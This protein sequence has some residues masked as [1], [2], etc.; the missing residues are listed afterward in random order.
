MKMPFGKYKGQEVEDI[1]SGYLLYIL[2]NGTDLPTSLIN[3]MESQLAMREGRGSSIKNDGGH[4][5]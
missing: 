3:E 4:K 2:E 1:P 5:Q